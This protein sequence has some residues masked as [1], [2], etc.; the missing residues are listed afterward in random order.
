[1]KSRIGSPA[2]GEPIFLFLSGPHRFSNCQISFTSVLRPTRKYF[3]A[4]GDSNSGHQLEMSGCDGC[5]PNIEYSEH[6]N[7]DFWKDDP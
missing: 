7:H 1:M 2:A 3:A 5:R 4:I 6:N